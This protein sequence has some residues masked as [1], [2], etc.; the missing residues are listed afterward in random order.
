MATN[1]RWTTGDTLTAAKLNTMV[2]QWGADADK[3]A[4]TLVGQSYLATDSL[5]VYISINGSTWT[6]Y[7]PYYF[8]ASDTLQN[9]HDAE[10]GG[11]YAA[12]T[13]VKTITINTSA[14]GS[15]RTSFD[16][17]DSTAGKTSYAKIYKNGVAY[18][19]EQSNT[20]V[21][22][23]KTEDFT[24][25]FVAGDT[26]ELWIHRVWDVSNTYVRN[27]RLSYDFG[28]TISTTNS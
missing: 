21:Y 1:N 10:A 22:A 9:S 25:D 24:D 28:K 18:G 20:E 6:C 26:L 23:T 5:Q 16:L 13:K 8:Y 12:Y 3:P 15:I 27:F 7:L 11:N 4:P 17:R 19:T 14:F 2:Q